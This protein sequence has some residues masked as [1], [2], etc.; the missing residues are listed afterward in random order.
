MRIVLTKIG[1]AIIPPFMFRASHGDTER[2]R[3]LLLLAVGFGSALLASCGNTRLQGISESPPPVTS[4]AFAEAMVV[5]GRSP[6][7]EGNH[8]STHLNG[9][10]FF[11]VMLRAIGRAE[12]S[13]TFESFVNK[14]STPVRQFSHAFADRAR[15]GVKVHLILDAF[16][17]RHFGEPF[18]QS[19]RDAGVE[20][21]LY[22]P[23]RLARPLR[24]NHRTHRRI[25]VV[26]GE[27]GFTGGAGWTDHW[28]GNA[29]VPEHWRDTQYQLRGP[30]VRD[31]QHC[32]ND[33]WKELTGRE[34]TGPD[35]FPP[36]PRVGRLTA[37]HVTGSPLKSG[38]TIGSTYLLAINA[39]RKSI[40]IEHSYFVPPKP[41]TEALLRA[42][43]RGVEIDV[44]VPGEHTDMPID[45]NACSRGHRDLLAAGVRMHEFL[46]TMMHGKLLV[47]DGAFTVVG[48]ANLDGRSFFIN[49]ENNVHVLG[50]TFARE[51][52]RMFESDLSRCRRLDSG[53]IP[54]RLRDLPMN[55]FAGMV[56]GQL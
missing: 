42:A 37:Q 54:H 41:I 47:V 13:V 32:F 34:L 1:T 17:S 15:A 45:R 52:T 14:R 18:L 56:A 24:Y 20:I 19:M 2:G 3:F 6:W 27:V 9:D 22:S 5:V 49:D 21:E 23:F 43:R 7:R 48:S 44:I 25:L 55:I 8:I 12:K 28:I 10:D 38:D 50:S 36:L 51:Q 31:L 26:D 39:A 46:P 33:N 29:R 4:A 35:Y 53:D 30:V 11:P 16:G 40:L